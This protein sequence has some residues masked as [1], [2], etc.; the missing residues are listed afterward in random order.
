MPLTHDRLDSPGRIEAWCRRADCAPEAIA[1]L[2]FP[3]FRLDLTNEVLWRGHERL[4]LPPRPFE[5]LRYLAEH[6]HRLVRQRELVEAVWGDVV[7]SESLL[8]THVFAL[9]RVLGDGVIETI[10]RR[11]YRFVP[12]IVRRAEHDEAV[13]SN[14]R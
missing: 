2:S 5:V 9:R 8:R 11:G 6:P 4:A 1:V 7:V 10:P 12:E 14:G 13:T 3:P